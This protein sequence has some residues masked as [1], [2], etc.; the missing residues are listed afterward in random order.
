MANTA[1]F[2][3]I[4]ATLPEVRLIAVL[5]NPVERAYSDYLMYRRDGDEREL[6]FRDALDKQADRAS[7]LERTGFYLT[8]GLYGAQLRPYFDEFPRKQLHVLLYE[9][10]QTDFLQAMSGIFAFI[11]VSSAF[12][13]TDLEPVNQSGLPTT[14]AIKAALE[15]RYRLRRILR[16]LPSS[17]KRRINRPIERRLYKPELEHADRVRLVDF[18]QSDVAEL[19]R[20]LDRDLSHWLEV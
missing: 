12:T 15:L 5:R 13:P 11:G 7:R 17:L 14:F 6:R 1:A 8:T 9:D 2:P 20:L 18:Y 3:R 4:A 16:P 10:L 19:G